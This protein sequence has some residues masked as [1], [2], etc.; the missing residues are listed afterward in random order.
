MVQFKPQGHPST[1]KVTTV[2]SSQNVYENQSSRVTC[3]KKNST[4][5]THTITSG[6]FFPGQQTQASGGTLPS[7]AHTL[8]SLLSSPHLNLQTS[9]QGCQSQLIRQRQYH[10]SQDDLTVGKDIFDSLQ[11]GNRIPV[12]N[13]PEHGKQIQTG[14]VQQHVLQNKS[15]LLLRTSQSAGSSIASRCGGTSSHSATQQRRGDLQEQSYRPEV[16]PEVQLKMIVV[17]ENCL[18]IYGCRAGWLL[19]RFR[20]LLVFTSPSLVE[21]L[22]FN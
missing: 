14:L 3:V 19:C 22:L 4:P 5:V 6:T 1:S 12:T 2:Q 18:H 21:I 10:F 13:L 8:V 20:M 9:V 15:S 7:S 17:A 11:L 16:V